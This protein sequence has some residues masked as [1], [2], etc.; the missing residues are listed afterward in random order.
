MEGKGDGGFN[1]RLLAVATSCVPTTVDL[2]QVRVNRLVRTPALQPLGPPSWFLLV[3]SGSIPTGCQRAETCGVHSSPLVPIAAGRGNLSPSKL[4]FGSLCLT[5]RCLCGGRRPPSPPQ[6]SK[7]S[8]TLRMQGTGVFQTDCKS[9][10]CFSVDLGPRC[11]RSQQPQAASVVVL[12]WGVEAA[13]AVEVPVGRLCMCWWGGWPC[14]PARHH[15][16]GRTQPSPFLHFHKSCSSCMSTFPSTLL[17]VPWLGAYLEASLTA[18]V[19]NDGGVKKLQGW[20]YGR[21]RLSLASSQAGGLYG[22]FTQPNKNDLRLPRESARARLLALPRSP[23]TLPSQQYPLSHPRTTASSWLSATT[24]P[25]KATKRRRKGEEVEISGGG[26]LGNP[27]V[28]LGHHS[29]ILWVE[30]L[31]T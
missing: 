26:A 1:V 28:V 10:S 31:Q 6:L 30:H 15:W 25:L 7:Q 22:C 2:G 20:L 17:L 27:P 14:V 29:V 3:G 11:P 4:W 8:T 13:Q 12:H 23:P 24:E 9:E 18:L 16:S 5:P 21:G 19:Q